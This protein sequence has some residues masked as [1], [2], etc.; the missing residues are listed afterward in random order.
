M[1]G[2]KTVCPVPLDFPIFV[3]FV[4]IDVQVFISHFNEGVLEM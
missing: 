1:K 4:L 3:S 2:N